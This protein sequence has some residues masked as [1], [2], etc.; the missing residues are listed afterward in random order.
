MRS[1]PQD[2]GAEAAVLGSMIVDPRCIGDVVERL[3]KAAFYRTEHQMIFAAI[4]QLWQDNRDGSLDGLLVRNEL[5][6]RKELDAVGGPDYLQQ[7]LDTVPSSANAEYYTEIVAEMALLRAIIASG[8]EIVRAAYDGGDP[9]ETLDAAEKAIF[10][11]TNKRVRNQA[12]PASDLVQQAFEGISKRQGGALTGLAT[13]YYEL[14]AMTAG[15]QDGDMILVGARPS[16][17]KTCLAMGI[18]ER[19]SVDGGIPVAVFSLEMAAAQLAERQL[20]SRARVDYQN[21]RKGTV[22]TEAFQKLVDAMSA[23]GAAPLYI[24]DTTGLTPLEL[25]AKARRLKNQY[26]IRLVVIDYLQ[27]MT[28][29]GRREASQEEKTSE[30]SRHVK[31]LARELSVPV[32]VVSQLSRAPE[33]RE[34]HEPRMS[35]LRYSGSLEQDADVI[36]LLHREDY[37]HRGEDGYVPDNTAKVIVAKQ[38]NGPTGI[39]KL[40]FLEQYVRFEN[41]AV[42]SDNPLPW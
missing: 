41:L 33:G 36:L 2:I 5:E 32:V 14:D 24:D 34:G 39:V 28:G 38:R 40:S 29:T 4:V 7:V 3:D 21:V 20:C 42:V 8:T 13:G 10:A 37:Y 23:I 6:R 26:G 22:T 18:A 31:T 27:L 17:G 12:R 16:M 1:L 9:K 25:R 11:I 19:A 30:L 35:D 15:L